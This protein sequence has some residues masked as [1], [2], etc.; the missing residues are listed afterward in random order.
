MGVVDYKRTIYEYEENNQ[1]K[2]VYL[3]DEKLKLSEFGKISENF[4]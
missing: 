2:F 4:S 3:L 1:K